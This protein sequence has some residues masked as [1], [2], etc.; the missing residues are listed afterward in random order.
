MVIARSEV[1]KHG[2]RSSCW[3]IIQGQVYDVTYFL[4]FH[5]GGASSILRY[6]GKDATEE[7]E[8]IHPPGTID[9]LPKEKHLGDCEGSADSGNAASVPNLPPQDTSGLPPLRT[10]QNLGDFRTTAQNSLSKKAW[11][12]YSSAADS[13]QADASNHKDWTKIHFRPRTLRRVDKI[14]TRARIMGH[15]SAL[16]VFIAPAALAKLAHEDGELCLGRGA[17]KWDIPYCCSTYSSVPHAEL[18]KSMETETST[19]GALLFQLYVPIDKFGA[20]KLI[21]EARRLHCRALVVTIDSAVIGKREEDDRL[22][23]QLDHEAG[24]VFVRA[25]TTAAP[26][27]AP[28]LRGAH[29]STLEWSDLAWIREAWGNAGPLV[30]KGVQTVEDAMLAAEAGVD[31]IY[32]SNH[33]GR[34]LDYAP[35]S[36]KTLLEI[37]KYC[38]SILNKLDIY[39]DGGVTRGSDVIKAL[40]LGAKAVGVGRPFM[41]SLSGYGT[42]GVE[43]VIQILD[44]EIQTTMRLLGVTAVSQLTPAYINTSALVNELSH[45]VDLPLPHSSSKL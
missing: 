44:D 6:G 36:I 32:L 4:D 30:L 23:A 21:Q 12:Y 20:K 29:T 1:E 38:P 11:I 10:L 19:R 3:V 5:P 17:V 34:Q 39:L 45:D 43:R 24:I 37:R 18:A 40:C 41:Y 15:D 27:D 33:G 8:L 26:P 7:Y 9:T 35:S 16:P 31:A 28:V 42:E 13:L 25:A 14:S 22:K 2:S